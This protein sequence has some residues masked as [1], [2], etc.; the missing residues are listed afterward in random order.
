M[1]WTTDINEFRQQQ[2]PAHPY[3]AEAYDFIALWISGQEQFILHTSGSTGSPKPIAIS[4]N[5]L[6]SSAAMTGKA[7]QLGKGTRALVCLNISYIAGLMMLVRGMELGW[8][9][10]VIEPVSNP[11]LSVDHHAEFDFAALV[12]L[13]LSQMLENPDTENHVNRLRKILLGGAPVSISLQRKID[14][15]TVPVYQSYGMTE[16]VSHVALRRLNGEKPELNFT[17]LPGIE[18]G[19]DA[20]KCLYIS[21][22]VTNGEKIQ[23]NDLAEIHGNSFKWIGRADNVI[24]SGGVK[25]VLDEVD[26]SIAEVLYNLKITNPFFVWFRPDEKLGQMLILIM[27]GTIDSVTPD[28]LLAE[29]RKHNSAYETPKHVYFVNQFTRTATDKVDKHKTVQ[30]LSGSSHG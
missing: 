7:L 11:L 20:R 12:P 28:F 4:R 24:N 16:T 2:R 18:F 30:S 23:T 21:G 8:K 14:N 27:E 22:P 17:F 29:I 6:T 10:T 5:Q 13:Q 26:T 9:L 1:Q 25:I 15:L 3:F 19:L